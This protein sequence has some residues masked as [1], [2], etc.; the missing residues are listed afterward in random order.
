M[1]KRIITILHF[2]ILITLIGC[3]PEEVENPTIEPT[4]ILTRI[5][6][7]PSPL[8]TRG[9][10][11][12]KLAKGNKQAFIATGHYS[13]GSSKVLSNLSLSAWRSSN[14]ETGF[15]SKSGVFSTGNTTGDVTVYLIKDNV[16]SNTVSVE[17]SAAVI[18]TLAVTPPASE[19]AMGQMRPLT[20]IATYSD[21]TSSD[22]SD[23][24]TWT[25]EALSTATVTPTG[26]LA[27]VDVGH[28]TITATKDNVT[29]NTVSVEVSAAVIT[30]LAVTPPAS[31][32]AMGQMRPLTAIATYSDGT[33]SDVSDSVTWTSEALSTAT[34]TPTG[35]LAGVDVGHTTITATKDNVTS[36]TVS[37]EVYICRNTGV[38]CTDVFEVGNGKLFTNS[39]SRIAL[40]SI[41]GSVNNGFTQE[42][43]TSGPAGNFV[44]FNWANANRLC[45]TYSNESLAGRTNWR[46]ATRN[47]LKLELFNTYGNMFNARGWPVRLNYWSSTSRGPGFLNVSL[48]GGNEGASLGEEELYASC[49]SV[50]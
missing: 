48:R 22:V 23:S 30:T 42:I 41:G 14:E 11:Q 43:G 27:G 46:L 18:T 2:F 40:H 33:S 1:L 32:L 16:T 21:G 25:S 13:D 50:P 35:R 10:S 12:L 37:V 44:W 8:K 39:P 28:T 36:N 6:I 24:V 31:E 4:A 19:L 20:A 47:E 7:I 3:N 26:R 17:V 15:F 38:S 45:N 34:V 5:D 9:T 49:V 29:S